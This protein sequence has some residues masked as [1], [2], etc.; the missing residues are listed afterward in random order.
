M[1]DRLTG[2]QNLRARFYD[3]S[4][5]RFNRLDPHL[6]FTDDP[7]SF[8]SHLYVGANPVNHIDPLGLFTYTETLTVVTT[9]AIVT[10]GLAGF[11]LFPALKA[12]QEFQMAQAVAGQ[13]G[14]PVSKTVSQARQ[15]GG[16]R[17]LHGTS[18]YAWRGGRIALGSLPIRRDFGRAFYTFHDDGL[19]PFVTASRKF[20][21]WAAAFDRAE[22][23]STGR[24]GPRGGGV[25]IVIV[26]K[27]SASHLNS[28][29]RRRFVMP[30]D[31]LAWQATVS[32]SRNGIDVLAAQGVDLAI[33]PVAR[34]P[35]TSPQLFTKFPDQWAFKTLKSINPANFYPV[36]V[37]LGPTTQI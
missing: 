24:H 2:M 1:T 23:I 16:I 4:L 14:V 8:N 36:T 30:V 5:G 22:Q 21:G 25:P 13:L 17:F 9:Q 11:A 29:N 10:V 20:S 15:F 31:F 6:G 33:G 27:T 26:F 12:A 37:V 18:S 34:G 32:Q 35:F 19:P 3:P 7:I 28:L